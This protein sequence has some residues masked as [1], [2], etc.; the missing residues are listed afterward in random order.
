[1]H[2]DAVIPPSPGVASPV[3]DSTAETPSIDHSAARTLPP[4]SDPLDLMFRIV[5]M[6]RLLDLISETGSGGAGSW[7][8]GALHIYSGTH[9]LS[10][11]DKIMID[12]PSIEAL[13][14]RLSPGSFASMTKVHPFSIAHRE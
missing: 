7:V 3:V 11:V 6:Y 12:K 4:G 10:T 8:L 9:Q 2:D 5:G 14:N 13:A 1:M